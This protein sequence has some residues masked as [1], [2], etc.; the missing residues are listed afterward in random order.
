MYDPYKRISQSDSVTPLSYD[1]P[2]IHPNIN[3]PK[4]HTQ[5]VQNSILEPITLEKQST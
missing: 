5:Q 1:A 2:D 4:V 3:S